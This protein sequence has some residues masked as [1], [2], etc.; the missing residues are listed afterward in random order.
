MQSLMSTQGI[1][2]T[3]DSDPIS[4]S[5]ERINEN[6]FCGSGICKKEYLLTLDSNPFTGKLVFKA[7][8]ATENEQKLLGWL[9]CLQKS[10]V[11][12]APP[13][14]EILRLEI[15][16]ISIKVFADGPIT[17]GYWE[18]SKNKKSESLELSGTTLKH[19]AE[20]KVEYQ[21]HFLIGERT[22]ARATVEV[23]D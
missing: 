11:D 6:G 19:L 8:N 3:L 14:T 7:P 9:G 10:G 22:A 4:C 15:Q 5:I 20:L 13:S 18:K 21:R 23:A 16:S 1:F 2:T 12:K 17:I